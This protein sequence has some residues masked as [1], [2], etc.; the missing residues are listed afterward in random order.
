MHANTTKGLYIKQCNPQNIWKLDLRML[1]ANSTHLIGGMVLLCGLLLKHWHSVKGETIRITWVELIRTCCNPT[2]I[3]RLQATYK[4]TTS[5]WNLI[6]TQKQRQS[7]ISPTYETMY[8]D[9][10]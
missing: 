5:R 10:S 7:N 3:F 2:I 1:F 6:P 9:T 8:R 4:K